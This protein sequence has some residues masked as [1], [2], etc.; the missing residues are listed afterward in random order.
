MF[1]GLMFLFSIVDIP[2]SWRESVSIVYKQGSN[3]SSW[4]MDSWLKMAPSIRIR[5]SDLF[6]Y[7]RS[8]LAHS[9][10]CI[11]KTIYVSQPFCM[12]R[13]MPGPQHGF[14]EITGKSSALSL[15]WNI[16]LTKIQSMRSYRQHNFKRCNWI[17][18]V[19]IKKLYI[20]VKNR[21]VLYRV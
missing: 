5:L 13:N 10:Y 7:I 2:S 15:D 20:W 4:A 11:K 21:S 3:R 8:V 18:R 16:I 14:A 9:A 17:I 6:H 19:S 1:I 12:A